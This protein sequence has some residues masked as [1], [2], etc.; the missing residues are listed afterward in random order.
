MSTRNLEDWQVLVAKKGDS[1][2]L[3]GDE[4][5]RGTTWKRG[6]HNV[7]KGNKQESEKTNL[8]KNKKPN[9]DEKARRRGGAAEGPKA[10]EAR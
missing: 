9:K 10:N 5:E 6:I 2:K 3:M 4:P 8:K 1:V 7:A